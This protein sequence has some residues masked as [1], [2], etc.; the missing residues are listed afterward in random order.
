M[1]IEAHIEGFFRDT[2]VLR[3]LDG[4]RLPSL[5]PNLKLGTVPMLDLRFLI[6]LRNLWSLALGAEACNHELLFFEARLGPFVLFSVVI[7]LFL[8]FI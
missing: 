8:D 6:N 1:V 5:G 3:R 7:A 2:K 4:L